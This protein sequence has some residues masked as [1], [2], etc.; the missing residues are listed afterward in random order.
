[1]VVV[2]NPIGKPNFKIHKSAISQKQ[3]G[4]SA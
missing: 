2:K 1:M 4:Q 3:Q